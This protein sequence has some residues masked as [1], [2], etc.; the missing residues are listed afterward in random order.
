MTRFEAELFE[1]AMVEGARQSRSARQ[2]LDHWARVGRAVSSSTSSQRAQVEAA[3][4]GELDM[5]EL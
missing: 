4:R 5:V 1:A 3:L 2:Q